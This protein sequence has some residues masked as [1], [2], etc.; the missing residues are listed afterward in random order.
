[1]N[2]IIGINGWV[3][4][5][6]YRQNCNRTIFNM[7]RATRGVP[8]DMRSCGAGPAPAAAACNR[9]TG[10][11]PEPRLRPL[12]AGARSSLTDQRQCTLH[13]LTKSAARAEKSPNWSAAKRPPPRKGRQTEGP[14]A[15]SGAPVPLVS[16]LRTGQNPGRGVD[17]ACAQRRHL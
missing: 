3:R 5:V 2:V 1:M 4:Q 6:Q 16:M 13:G 17:G 8:A 10:T 12:R 7:S 14:I 11:V 15:P 9:R